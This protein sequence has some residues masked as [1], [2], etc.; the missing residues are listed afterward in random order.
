MCWVSSYANLKTAEEN[1]PVVK[2]V[3]RVEDGTYLPYYM[4]DTKFSYTKGI[5][6]HSILEHPRR[7]GYDY[8]IHRGIHSYLKECVLVDMLIPKHI[9][10][11]SL[12]TL[13]FSII[14]P[15]YNVDWLDKYYA[16]TY[17]LILMECVIPK[18]SHYYINEY[19]EVVSDCIIPTKF[20]DNIKDFKN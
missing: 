18:G 11:L 5:A 8:E 4:R 12:N 20:I 7:V 9:I 13:G 1:V 17:D 14:I 15:Y 3:I 6:S 19:G 10:R 16:R 2:V